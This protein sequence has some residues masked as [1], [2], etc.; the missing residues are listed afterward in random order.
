MP[1]LPLRWVSRS[2]V[3]LDWFMR[4]GSAAFSTQE[5]A[6]FQAWL[7][8]DAAHQEAFE[9]Y[10][11]RSSDIDQI[12]PE[13]RQLLQANLAYDTALKAASMRSAGRV[14]LSLNLNNL[15]D[16]SYLRTVTPV[17]TTR[18]ET[19]ATYS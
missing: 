4:R 16:R 7:K 12:P 5:E 2:K 9:L 8:S 11:R 1:Q 13:L 3:A 6:L 10:E 17:I 14:S 18:G 19:L 15:T